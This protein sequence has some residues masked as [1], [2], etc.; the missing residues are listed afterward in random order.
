[1]QNPHKALPKIGDKHIYILRVIPKE[2]SLGKDGKIKIQRYGFT[3]VPNFGGTA[4][5]YCGSSLNA[6]IGD[7]LPWSSK[8]QRDAALRAYIIKSRV[9]DCSRLLL[10]QPYSP[11]LTSTGVRIK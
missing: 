9:K 3:I 8:A 1:M 11:Q 5:F 7:L 2:W 6:C 10:P 4:H